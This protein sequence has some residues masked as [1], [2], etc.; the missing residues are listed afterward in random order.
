MALYLHPINPLDR[1]HWPQMEFKVKTAEKINK[2]MHFPVEHFFW[3][4]NVDP[5]PV[6]HQ[7]LRD[8]NH[9]QILDAED[10]KY[11][12]WRWHISI[13]T[14]RIEGAC[15]QGNRG[16]CY[17]R[18][19]SGGR[20]MVPLYANRQPQSVTSG[21][22]LR[23]DW[24]GRRIREKNFQRK[25]ISKI[26]RRGKDADLHIYIF[27]LANRSRRNSEMTLFKLRTDSSKS[28]FKIFEEQRIRNVQKRFLKGL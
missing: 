3:F 20:S 25:W 8:E 1:R 11:I 18:M 23:N 14:D 24:K 2:T 17:G 27:Q 10:R 21:I 9:R 28:S 15:K 13:W 12:S 5:G 26:K 4:D 22:F 16:F 6:G 19:H 7:M